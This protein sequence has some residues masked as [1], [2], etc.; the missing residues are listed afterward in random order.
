MKTKEQII[1]LNKTQKAFYNNEESVAK[2]NLFSRLWR[3]FR[4]G[5]L[6]GY[7]KK[8]EIRQRMYD[9]H[10]VWMGDLSDKKVLDLGCLRGNS[11][12]LYMAQHAKQY[13]GID[14]SDKATADLQA[15]ID[16]LNCPNAKALA[17]DFLSDDFRESDFDIIYAF[18]VLHHFENFDML[19]QRLVEKLKKNGE[20]M[21][22]DPLETSAP[23]VLL[24]K[25]YRPFQQDKDWEWPFSRKSFQQIS[26]YFN[27]VELRGVL[28]KS[29]Y[30]LLLH[31]LPLSAAFKRQKIEKMVASDWRAQKPNEVLNCMQVTMRLQRKA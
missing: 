30:G 22:F 15:K 19:M 17:V 9:L 4:N 20:V 24:R 5:P 25:M 7:Q 6:N 16:A 28:G 31:M 1:A 8:Y 21:S 27:I 29:K 2:P 12:S 18:G 23:V 10:R 13:I 26:C 11:L 14:L 3:D